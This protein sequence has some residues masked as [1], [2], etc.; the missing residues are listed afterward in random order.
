MKDSKKGI[1]VLNVSTNILNSQNLRYSQILYAKAVL[2]EI[3]EK[4]AKHQAG[5]LT[6]EMEGVER[7]APGVLNPHRPAYSIETVYANDRQISD[8]KLLYHL[9]FLAEAVHSSFDHGDDDELDLFIHINY[10]KGRAVEVSVELAE[11]T[12]AKEL[13]DPEESD[14]EESEEMEEDDEAETETEE[15]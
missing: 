13:E 1:K 14:P 15:D 9:R 10:E 4:R 12:E 5:E 7:T 11:D 6:I 8:K 2:Q 3:V